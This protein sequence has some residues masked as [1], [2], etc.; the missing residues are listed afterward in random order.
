MG[1]TA[2]AWKI[3]GSVLVV[4]ATVGALLWTSLREEIQLW[5]FVD[6]VGSAPA[7]RRLNVGG[8][9][10]AVRADPQTLQYEFEIESRPPRPAA[11]L[12]AHYRGLVPDTFKVGAEVVATGQ[13]AAD[14]RLAVETVMA[15]C[16][17]KYEVPSGGPLVAK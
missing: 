7:G 16:P 15:K 2:T 8:R 11:V 10:R 1:R 14:G 4:T 17:S 13:L 12:T 5:K 9:V 6:E 3:V